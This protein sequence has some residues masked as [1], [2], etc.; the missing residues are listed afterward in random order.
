MQKKEKVKSTL[1]EEVKNL[2]D[3]NKMHIIQIEELTVIVEDIYLEK[4]MMPLQQKRKK[5]V[6]EF[7]CNKCEEPFTS[8]E[9]SEK[10]RLEIHPRKLTN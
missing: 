3:G 5:Q 4:K 7:K 9:T 10:H 6:I 1:S 2:I 8:N